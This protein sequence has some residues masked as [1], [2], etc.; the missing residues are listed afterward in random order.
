MTENN[1]IRHV[2]NNAGNR[3]SRPEL[4]FW[5]RSDLDLIDPAPRHLMSSSFVSTNVVLNESVVVSLF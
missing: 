2:T 3:M 5:E 4:F 1:V